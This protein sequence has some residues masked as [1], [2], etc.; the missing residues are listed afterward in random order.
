[1][2]L[3]N[4]WATVNISTDGGK[5]KKE[6]DIYLT[7]LVIGNVYVKTEKSSDLVFR[8]DLVRSKIA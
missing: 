2:I 3:L 8:V 1:M 5:R 7:V 4:N 6:K